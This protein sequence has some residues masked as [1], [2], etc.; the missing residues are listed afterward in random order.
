[1][2]VE[3]PEAQQTQN[4]VIFPENFADELQGKVPGAKLTTTP[5]PIRLWTGCVSF[6]SYRRRGSLPPRDFARFCC[7]KGIYRQ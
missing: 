3:T 6:G 1:M 7:A 5:S 4:D 2:P